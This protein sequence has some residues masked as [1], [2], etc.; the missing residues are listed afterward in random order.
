MPF[1]ERAIIDDAKRKVVNM[2][3]Q[4]QTVLLRAPNKTKLLAHAIIFS[5]HL[6]I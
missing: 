3:Q 5:N 6:Q 1:A 2:F 4:T